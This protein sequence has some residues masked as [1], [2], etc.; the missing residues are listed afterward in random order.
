MSMRRPEK[1]FYDTDLTDTSIGSGGQAFI[2]ALGGPAASTLTMVDIKQGVGEKERIGRKCTITNIYIRLTVEWITIVSAGGSLT[3]LQ[4]HERIR[5][6]LFWDKQCN[7]AAANFVDILESDKINSF[8][9]LANNK[10]FVIL[11]D[12]TRD[13]SAQWIAAGDGTANDEAICHR[14]YSWKITKK[15][16]IPI[17]YNSTTGALSEIRSNNIGLYAWSSNGARMRLVTNGN[18]VSKTRIRF[19]DY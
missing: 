2:A 14:E 5:I 8:R 16:F 1:K 13:F 18:S 17:E 9:N 7:G 3:P 4:G 11:Y 15:V 10:R 19:I 12:K 6:I